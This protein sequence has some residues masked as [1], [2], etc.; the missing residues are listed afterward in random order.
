MKFD[1]ESETLEFKKSTSELKE[2][3]VSIC[4]ML[5]KHGMGALYFGVKPDG[6]LIGQS[7]AESTL[8]DVSR[9]IYER[10]KPQIFPVI[11]KVNLDNKPLIKVEFNGSEP[12]YS[13]N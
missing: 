10:I 6:T 13:M 9:M 7:V 5:N 11:E 2:A 1:M 12:P 8:R 3:C 4:A